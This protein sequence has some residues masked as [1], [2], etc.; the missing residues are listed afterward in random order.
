MCVI[1]D[2]PQRDPRWDYV[3]G[4]YCSCPEE[5]TGTYCEIPFVECEGEHICYNGGRCIPGLAQSYDA[6]DLFCNCENAFDE[7]GNRYVG[8]HCE[9]LVTTYCSPG[10][11]LFCL[12]GG[13]CNPNFPGSGEPCDC[14][15]ELFGEHCEY[16]RQSVP[17]L[18]CTLDCRN[19]GQCV[20]GESPIEDVDENGFHNYL[21]TN[22]TDNQYCSCPDGYDGEFCEVYRQ[23]CGEHF[24]FNGG[25][26]KE[27][28]IEGQLVFFCDCS[29]AATDNADYAGRFCQFKAT[30]Y[31]TKN[32]GFNENLFCVNNGRCRDIASQGCDCDNP[33]SGFSCEFV[34]QEATTNNTND[35]S[36]ALPGDPEDT[37]ECDID[38]QNGGVCRHGKKD[39]GI[40]GNIAG[41]ATHL[42]ETHTEDYKHCVCPDGF[43]GLYCEEKAQLCGE[44][45]HICLHGSSCVKYGDEH[46]CDCAD[47]S[48]TKSQTGLFSGASCEHPVNDV[49][50]VKYPGPGQPL[51]FCVNGGSCKKLVNLGEPH[52][53]C[54]CVDGFG[55]QH[56]EISSATNVLPPD[57]DVPVDP[58]IPDDGQ[59]EL[60]TKDET[61]SGKRVIL[62]VL[63]LALVS[64]VLL[65]FYYIIPYVRRR[66]RRKTVGNNI[67]WASN[68]QDDP[69]EINLAPRRSSSLIFDQYSSSTDPFVTHLGSLIQT[70][71][72]DEDEEPEPQVFI[73]PPRD[74]D[75]HVL[76]NVDII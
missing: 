62:I 10:K 56:C 26:C 27:S 50:T 45:E 40:L 16:E 20:L 14:P 7:S 15:P 5:W 61:R 75:G 53:G 52:P 51:L 38:C 28:D 11:T 54:N 32:A 36:P 70:H 76:H 66:R 2:P 35:E 46:Y 55:G 39:L 41:N 58:A 19:G 3:E 13:V 67:R 12:N 43:V 37:T 4:M 18:E 71:E 49:C 30:S 72:E 68:Y 44:G 21:A 25:T 1:G 57:V 9:Q 65:T 8:K 33:F 29:T 63:L 74:E 59:S 6:S 69:A 60:H 23:P 48:S 47:A 64:T 24:C 22:K 34:T 31:C 73:G 17:D 42:N